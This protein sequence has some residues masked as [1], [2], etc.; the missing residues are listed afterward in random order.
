MVTQMT[1]M[2]CV[3][4]PSLVKDTVATNMTKKWCI[5]S[6]WAARGHRGYK[7]DHNVVHVVTMGG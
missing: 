3:M 7:K 1:K 6:Q 2:W 4:S 5:L